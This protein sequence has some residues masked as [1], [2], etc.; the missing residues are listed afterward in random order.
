MNSPVLASLGP[1]A[2]AA[3]LV[4]LGFGVLFPVLADFTTALGLSKLQYG[5][6]LSA[7]PAAGIVAAPLWGRFSD[8]HGRRPAIVVG[9]VGFAISFAAFGLGSS[10][11]TLIAARI[12]GGLLSSAALPAAFAYAA[13]VTSSEQRS[14]AMGLMGAAVGLGVTVGPAIGGSLMSLGLRAPYFASAGIGA[15]GALIVWRA[16]PESLTA[17][18]RAQLLEEQAQLARRGLTRSRIA[19]LL[20]PLLAASFL[21]TA[22]RLSIDVTLRFLVDERLGGS[23]MQ[24]GWLM[25]G[26]GV[27]IIGVQGGAIRPLVARSGEAAL[28]AL[29][30]AIMAVGLLAAGWVASWSGVILAGLAI[31]VGFALHAPTLTS[32]LS[33]AGEQMQGVTQGLNNSAQAAARVV[34]PTIFM[35]LYS[36]RPWTAYVLGALLALLAIGV[37]LAGARAAQDH[38]T[39]DVS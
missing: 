16:L 2:L 11:E 17:G 24:V 34:A 10:F 8:R 23:A 9:L 28:F 30:S 36:T 4:M 22:A 15:L 25:F 32:L 14:H 6:I 38:G 3:F 18:R 5:L 20:W 31:A 33:R 39:P 26:M 27:I 1:A 12:V 29:G 35:A 19:R 13:D 21:L 37:G 7:W